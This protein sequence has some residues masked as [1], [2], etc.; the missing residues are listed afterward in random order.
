MCLE[1]Q[2][3]SLDWCLLA[4]SAKDAFPKVKGHHHL[5]YLA[6]FLSLIR[7]PPSQKRISF[8]LELFL[9]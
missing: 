4:V 6:L 2:Q 5:S 8:K 9:G 3:F 1:A 7:N